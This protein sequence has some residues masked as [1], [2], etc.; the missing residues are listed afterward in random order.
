MH[1]CR[2]A[3]LVS[4]MLIA[5]MTPAIG[6]VLAVGPG[7][8]FSTISAAV[9]AANANDVIDVQA[10]TYTNDFPVI[11]IPLTINAVGG[12]AL[13]QATVNIPNQMGIL[14]ANS[15]ITINGLA[16][17]GASVTDLQGGNGAGIRYKGGSLT[18]L[19]SQFLDNQDGILA[20]PDPNGV[21]V[22]KNS[23]F[24]DNGS[25]TGYTHALYAGQIKSLTVENSI[26]N[27]TKV[28]H[29]IK[30]RAATT[31][32]TGNYLDDGLTGTTSYAIDISNGGNATITG[33]QIVQ[34]PNTQNL[35][36]IAYAAEGEIYSSNS[37]FV[38]GDTFTN[39]LPGRSIG[40]FNHTSDVDAVL[41]DDVFNNVSNPLV[42][43]GG[44]AVGR[45]P[46]PSTLSLGGPLIAML[47]WRRRM[48]NRSKAGRGSTARRL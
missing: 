12:T 31:L 33:N 43:P 19:N 39:S 17:E 42:G 47:A 32:V 27:G 25:G 46:E 9:A 5:G 16:F 7:D 6:N 18:V 48:D 29:D 37:L 8:P 23:T 13:L 38:A 24:T 21:I 34:G 22:V 14:I 44:I 26:F 45:L 1:T 11:N 2:A 3:I 28:G 41:Q 15:T 35:T 20:D 4:F 10:G 30:S 36:M 40:V